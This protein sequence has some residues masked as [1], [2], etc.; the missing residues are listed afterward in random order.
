MFEDGL[1]L[2]LNL[3]IDGTDFAIP[4]GAIKR[5]RAVCHTYGFEA[6]V[7]FN[8]SCEQVADE[9]FPKFIGK[10][11]IAARLVFRGVEY[12]EPVADPVTMTL[13]G[14]VSDKSVTEIIGEQMRGMPVMARRYVI[15]FADPASVL[16]RE[17][18]P[19]DL[20]VGSTLKKLIGAHCAEGIR[21]D[22]DWDLLD[23]KHAILCLGLGHDDSDA[24][25]Y[26]FVAW[27][28]NEYHGAFELD[29]A[30]GRYRLGKAKTRQKPLG[31]LPA[32]AVESLEVVVP[33]TIRHETRVL[34]P[35]ANRTQQQTITQGQS[36]SGVRQDVLALTAIPSTF[37]NRT[38]LES[39]RLTAA[40]MELSVQLS[41]LPR[42][43]FMPGNALTVEEGFSERLY[44]H[45]RKYRVREISLQGQACGDS[46]DPS[47]QLEEDVATYAMQMEARLELERNPIPHLPA[48]RAPYYPIF[49]EGK[50][51]A[52]GGEA[53]DRTWFALEN[54]QTSLHYNVVHVPLWNKEVVVPFRPDHLP[55]HFFFPVYKNERVLLELHFNSGSI[56]RYLDWAKNARLPQ[57]TQGN[58]IVMGRSAQSGTI[59]K[60]VYEDAKP[61]LNIDRTF[62]ADFQSVEIHEG[63]IVIH[64][65]EKQSAK[66]VEPKYDVVINVEA[67]KGKLTVAVG[68]SVTQVTGRFQSATG[69]VTGAIETAIV[70]LDASLENMENQVFGRIESV[71]AELEALAETAAATVERVVSSVTSAKGEI[72]AAIRE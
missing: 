71:Q 20:Q 8:I 55:G 26:D 41:A 31:A 27:L 67:A 1:A 35:F 60:H 39:A 12:N 3:G 19:C 72:L 9:L 40:G 34:N 24:N 63:G 4:G 53:D 69:Q 43:S 44:A 21:I 14:L 42:Q 6:D 22:Y 17:H 54:D 29:Y 37:D 45:G 56:A 32:D 16:W 13:R 7:A 33:E 25:F 10:D 36:V 50:V 61:K 18:R 48:F 23:E 15:Q 49:V 2:T 5:F 38:Q 57:N 58:Q 52:V 46:T 64:V 51:V 62:G 59:I 47:A 28:T 66:K 65:E 68:G 70:D 11:L 30:T